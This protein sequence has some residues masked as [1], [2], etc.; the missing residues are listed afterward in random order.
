VYP[1]AEFGWKAL[2]A[3]CAVPYPLCYISIILKIN[4]RTHDSDE[5]IASVIWVTRICDIGTTL[6]VTRYDNN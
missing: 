4:V 5:P 6:E 1:R 2:A 3:Y